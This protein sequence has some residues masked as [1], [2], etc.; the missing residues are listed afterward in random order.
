MSLEKLIYV[1][2]VG[3]GAAIC[4]TTGTI[5]IARNYQH[6]NKLPATK[7][8]AFVGNT[9]ERS[10]SDSPAILGLTSTQSKRT[11]L[12]LEEGTE[13]IA[14]SGPLTNKAQLGKGAQ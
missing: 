6:P 12:T 13:R 1:N 10:G 9:A 8:D 14:F 4:Q 11:V 3:S 7:V 2:G 5:T